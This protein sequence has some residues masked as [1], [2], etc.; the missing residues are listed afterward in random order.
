MEGADYRISNIF[1]PRTEEPSYLS[2]VQNRE[3]SKAE[4]RSAHLTKGK[5]LRGI[6]PERESPASPQQMGALS[7]RPQACR[8]KGEETR[9]HK[10]KKKKRA[11][12]TAG[13]C[14]TCPTAEGDFTHPGLWCVIVLPLLSWAST[15][16]ARAVFFCA[17]CGQG[18]E[19][20]R[21]K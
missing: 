12:D 9:D 6:S 20:E 13:L 2:Q 4:T 21:G 8:A 15:L 1:L 19:R 14:D 18:N 17:A 5:P 3:V 7:L 11:G 10:K 16:S